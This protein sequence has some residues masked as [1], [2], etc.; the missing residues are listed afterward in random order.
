MAKSVLPFALFNPVIVVLPITIELN[1][2][3]KKEI[4]LHSPNE[5]MKQGYL[6]ASKWFNNVENIWRIHRTALNN[7]YSSEQ[8]LNFQNK[9]VSQNLNA[10]YLVLYNALGKDAHS[11]VIERTKYDLDFIVD[12]KSYVFYTDSCNEAYYLTGILNAT[13]PN[14]LMKDFQARGL[15]GARGV[16]KKILD[17]YYPQFDESNETHQGLAALSQTAHQKASAYL[18]AFPPKQELSA[19]HLGRLRVEIKKHLAT[20][21]KEIDLLVKKLIG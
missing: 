1:N 4:K 6:N 5:L 3:N 20:E 17:I 10:P 14:E 8:Y 9:I 15:F 2:K 13:A 21:M 11:V 12:Y 19:I 7:K 18:Q 16:E